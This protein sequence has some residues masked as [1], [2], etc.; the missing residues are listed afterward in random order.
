MTDQ[1]S[2]A[3]LCCVN[4]TVNMTN[5]ISSTNTSVTTAIGPAAGSFIMLSVLALLL[6]P[7]NQASALSAN[8]SRC[9]APL[10]VTHSNNT[11]LAAT[12]AGCELKHQTSRVSSAPI[13]KPTSG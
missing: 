7:P 5:L 2:A 11:R 3:Q 6:I 10:M 1:I 8:P 12:I 4:S 13:N 9:N